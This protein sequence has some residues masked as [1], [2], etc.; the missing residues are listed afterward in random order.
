MVLVNVASG[1]SRKFLGPYGG[2][3]IIVESVGPPSYLEDK[4]L[5]TEDTLGFDDWR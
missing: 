1:L 3:E 5:V 4:L 2:S